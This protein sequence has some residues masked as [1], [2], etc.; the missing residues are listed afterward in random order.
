MERAR[1]YKLKIEK[2]Q[3]AALVRRLKRGFTPRSSSSR[4]LTDA[5]REHA[6]IKRGTNAEKLA[7]ADA[8][9]A[10]AMEKARADFIAAQ[11][12]YRQHRF[13]TNSA[14]FAASNPEASAQLKRL[15]KRFQAHCHTRSRSSDGLARSAEIAE[16]LRE[17]SA[18]V[19]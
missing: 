19:A 3:H 8:R 9:V 18:L 1:L 10:A 6:Y 17:A 2:I 13:P 16:V 11:E 7:E 12:C 15:H 5:R 14:S 4:E